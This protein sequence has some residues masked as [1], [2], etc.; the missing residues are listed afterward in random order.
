MNEKAKMKLRQT[1]KQFEMYLKN[2]YK[3]DFDDWK[4]PYWND[5][6]LWIW[7][8]LISILG[9]DKHLC[10]INPFSFLSR[11]EIAK[12]LQSPLVKK[13]LFLEPTFFSLH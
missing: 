10:L 7:R 13:C 6:M 9:N 8:N 2:E 5:C 1:Q 3:I 11:A 12:N 4:A